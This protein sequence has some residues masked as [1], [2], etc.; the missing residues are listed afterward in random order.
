MSEK[1]VG[2]ERRRQVLETRVV[3]KCWRRVLEKRVGE[4]CW[5]RVR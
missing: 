3:E 5:R 1:S 2:G 4:Q